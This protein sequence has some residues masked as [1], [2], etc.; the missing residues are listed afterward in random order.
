MK[1]YTMEQGYTALRNGL[2]VDQLYKPTWMMR[3]DDSLSKLTSQLHKALETLNAPVSL[4]NIDDM[5]AGY[6]HLAAM[7]A[8][9]DEE[10][11]RLE[12]GWRQYDI[13]EVSRQEAEVS[14]LRFVILAGKAIT[15]ALDFYGG[16]SVG[17]DIWYGL[18][19]A[20]VGFWDRSG[21]PD[22]TG[23]FL[24]ECAQACSRHSHSF[25]QDNLIYVE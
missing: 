10:G 1:E 12:G 16:A 15:P 17:N 11:N 5:V 18:T 13:S 23:R 20:G 14:V 24:T 3:K 8:T 19:H 4:A 22:E 6:L 21:I 7:D 2:T 9:I 25:V